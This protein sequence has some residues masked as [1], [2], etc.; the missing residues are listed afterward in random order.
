VAETV[1][2]QGQS[3]L[4]RHP[5]GVLGLSIVTLGIY[6]LY[7]YYQV[8]VE[9][10]RFEKDDTVRP[11]VALLAMALG[12]LVIVPPFISM[13]NT[14]LHVAKMEERAKVPVPLSPAINIVI[15]LVFAF[16]TA[17]YTQEHL[18]RVWDAAGDASGATPPLPPLPPSPVA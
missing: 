1:T 13:Y 6:W 17:M 3:Y 4:K 12:W 9:I 7:W 8:N 18:N 15:L 16:G 10:R 11:G 2:V 14:S 5:L